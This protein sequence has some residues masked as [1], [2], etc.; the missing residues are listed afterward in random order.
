MKIDI[1]VEFIFFIIYAICSFLIALSLTGGWSALVIMVYGLIFYGG[2]ALLLL[3]RIIYRIFKKKE[4]DAV[5]GLDKKLISLTL[6]TQVL[7]FSTI[8]SDGGDVG[9]GV[10]YGFFEYF[11]GLIRGS[12]FKSLL[13]DFGPVHNWYVGDHLFIAFSI[14]YLMFLLITLYGKKPSSNF[15]H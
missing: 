15:L 14:S 8:P 1:V 3:I 4:G 6:F 9:G 10:S 7:T 5:L 12:E 2:I 13:H 11:I